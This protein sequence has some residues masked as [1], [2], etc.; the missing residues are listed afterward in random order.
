MQES[1]PK[2]GGVEIE[3]VCAEGWKERGEACRREGEEAGKRIYIY[4][5]S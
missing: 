5:A 4:R 3:G 1:D 2:M